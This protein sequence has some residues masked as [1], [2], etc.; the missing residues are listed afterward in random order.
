MSMN[1]DLRDDDYLLKTSEYQ[2]RM[3]NY[4]I[5]LRHALRDGKLGNI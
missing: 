5:P 2:K 1:D 4:E 3:L